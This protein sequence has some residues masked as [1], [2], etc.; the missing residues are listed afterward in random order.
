MVLVS[1]H[2]TTNYTPII[3]SNYIENVY[4]YGIYKSIGSSPI[5]KNNVINVKY[6]RGIS[7]AHRWTQSKYLII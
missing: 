6:D 7:I 4:G 3:D 2:L 5:I 1:K